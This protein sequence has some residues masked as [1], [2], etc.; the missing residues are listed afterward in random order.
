MNY[1]LI[2]VRYGEIALKGKNRYRFEDRLCQNIRNILKDLSTVKV[3]KSYG[4]IFIAL[5]GHEAEP[6]IERLKNV[7][8]LVSF[9]PVKKTTLDIE[10]IKETALAVIRATV[11][12]P[13]TFKVETKRPNK[14][15]PLKSPEISLE[16]GAHLLVNNPGLK[17]DVHNP[18]KTV[19]IEIR[20]EGAY[21]F[22]QFVQGIGGMPGGSSGRAIAL[23]SGGIDSPVAVWYGMRRGL[24]VEGIH[25]HTYPI[26]SVESVQ[27]VIDLAKTLA[28]Y[29]GQFKLHLVP[30][31]DI[32]KEIKD[33]TPESHNITL[34]RRYFLRIAAKLAEKRDALALITGD[35]LG[36]VASQTLESMNVINQVTNLPIL[37]PLITMDKQEIIDVAKQIN[38]YEDSIR[39]FA[40]CCTLFV[41]RSPATK[42][43]AKIASKAEVYMDIENLINDALLKSKIISLTPH[44]NFLAKDLLDLK[45]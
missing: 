43:I 2:L 18:E 44:S 37:R 21:I 17:V 19:T 10:Q 11:P 22:S 33:F 24:Q 8:G 13:S 42:P 16:V 15:F 45:E 4:R 31:L 27:K 35:S 9:S 30:F 6:V 20:E 12:S 41:P 5:N 14:K 23:L 29:S 1:D 3:T 40:D 7:F 25:F 26:T 39:P 32:Q 38:T 34:M 36:Q 28:S